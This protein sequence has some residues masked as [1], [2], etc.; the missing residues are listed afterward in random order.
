[1]DH[2]YPKQEV[3]ILGNSKGE[4]RRKVYRE[5]IKC[6][7]KKKRKGHFVDFEE[8]G[9]VKVVSREVELFKIPTFLAFWMTV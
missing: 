1:M 3:N 2:N 6:K 8:A 9:G 7:K 5:N 4:E